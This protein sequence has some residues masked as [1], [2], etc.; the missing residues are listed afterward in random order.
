MSKD[1]Q[2]WPSKNNCHS[3]SILIHKPSQNR[4][5]NSWDNIWHREIISS[6]NL[7][8]MVLYLKKFGANHN[9]VCDNCVSQSTWE[10][11]IYKNIV[12]LGK[13]APFKFIG[14]CDIF[15][16][17]KV[18]NYGNI[19]SSI[20][21]PHHFLFFSDIIFSSLFIDFFSPEIN[22]NK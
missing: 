3:M 5:K 20:I 10:T 18:F 6:F 12:K 17:L 21:I 16:L 22:Y 2:T 11:S 14:L 13:I 7:G 19:L 1:Y 4:T 15:S 9:W 8:H